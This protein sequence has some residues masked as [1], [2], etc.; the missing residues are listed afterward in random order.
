MQAKIEQL[1]A[2]VAQTFAKNDEKREQLKVLANGILTKIVEKGSSALDPSEFYRA[3]VWG[4]IPSREQFEKIAFDTPE[5]RLAYISKRVRKEESEEARLARKEALA[6]AKEEKAKQK[7]LRAKERAEKAEQRKAQKEAAKA[8]KVFAPSMSVE[9]FQKATKEERAIAFALCGGTYGEIS[10]FY[11]VSNGFV[12]KY[13]KLGRQLLEEQA[14]R[15]HYEEQA[16]RGLFDE[17]DLQ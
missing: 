10:K 15:G 11:G 4:A 13:L 14:D 6:E 2:I 17:K 1:S 16:D 7:A 9:D 8:K 3:W 5:N 12:N